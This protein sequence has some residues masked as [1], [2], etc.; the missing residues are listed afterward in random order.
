[1]NWNLFCLKPLQSVP[2]CGIISASRWSGERNGLKRHQLPLSSTRI[3]DR[4]SLEAPGYFGSP[5]R[6]PFFGGTSIA[7][8]LTRESIRTHFSHL[9]TPMPVW[10]NWQTPWIQNPVSARTCGFDPRHRH[11]PGIPK[12]LINQGFRDSY[13]YLEN[14][15]LLR[16]IVKD[17]IGGVDLGVV[18]QVGVDVAGRPDVAVTKP[19]LNVLE[20]HAVG[21]QKCGT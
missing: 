7:D 18:V 12:A 11:H 9:K 5:E 14:S 8:R 13:F 6:F 3:H 10:W 21:V 19:F 16:K 17:L 15:G 1:M 4:E 2:E 20:C